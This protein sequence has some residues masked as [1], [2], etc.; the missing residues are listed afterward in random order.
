MILRMTALVATLALLLAACGAPAAQ[1]PAAPTSAPAAE[2]PVVP[3]S[4]PA[5]ESTAAPTAPATVGLLP[6]ALYLIENQIFRLEAADLERSQVTYEVPVPADALPIIALAVSPTDGSLAYIVQRGNETVLVRS[7]PRGEDPQPIYAQ[8]GVN[9]AAP[10]FSPDGARLAILLSGEG[11]AGGVYLLPAAGGD[12]ELLVANPAFDPETLAGPLD[13][14]LRTHTP[15]RFSPDGAQLL[16]YQGYL[17]IEG[18]D[19]AVVSLAEGAVTTLQS[20]PSL[21]GEW[22]IA[23][24]SGLAWAPDSSAVYFTP[25]RIGAPEGNPAIWRAEVATGA[26]RAI[27]PA[28]GT[29]PLMLYAHPFAMADGTLLVLTAEVDE[30]PPSFA[31]NPSLLSYGIARFDPA[32]GTLEQLRPAAPGNVGQV[33]WAPDGSGL[34][35]LV[36]AEVGDPAM[37]YLPAGPGESVQ[38]GGTFAN[39]L[40]FAW[41]Y[42]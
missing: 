15:V 26:S 33:T 19:L 14:S 25:V 30:L 37:L 28:P 40:S 16:L 24:G 20:P 12:P 2:P 6:A 21:E 5:V 18:C 9:V 36:F 3:T 4:T 17:Q 11:F 39:L 8:P 42:E 41:A 22:T 23:C 7:G 13:P 38:L 34:A 35:S 31:E 27:T 32:N 29:G 10:V 1:P